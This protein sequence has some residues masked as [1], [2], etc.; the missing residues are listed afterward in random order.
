MAK[1]FFSVKA[2]AGFTVIELLV[3]LGIMITIM[4]TVLGNYPESNIRVNLA[5]LAHTI[6][7]ALRETQIRGTAIDSSDLSVGGYG[8][9]FDKAT[10]TQFVL[11]KDFATVAGPNGL[12]VGDGVYSMIFGSDETESITTFP[13]KFKVGKLCVGTGYPFTGTN[14][15]SCDTDNTASMPTINTV[16]IAFVRP[17]PQPIIT[18]NQDD[19]L[20]KRDSISN[21]ISGACIEVTSESPNREAYVRSAQVYTSGRIVASKVGC[22]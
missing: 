13:Y 1:R 6:T 5:M 16:T 18:I 3:S 8:L 4:T 2:K 12:D 9:F 15:G 7:L 14:N 22:Q 11:F 10:S 20:N 17:S 21:G 19:A